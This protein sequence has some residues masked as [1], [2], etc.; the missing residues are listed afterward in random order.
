MPHPCERPGCGA[1]VD[2]GMLL[3]RAHWFQVPRPL[4]AAVWSTW[5]ALRKEHTV[6]SVRAYR[7][8]RDAAIASITLAAEVAHG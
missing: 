1:T 6:E 3:C 2:D 4:R 7:D 8:A 5:G